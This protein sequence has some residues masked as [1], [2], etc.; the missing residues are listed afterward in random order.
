MFSYSSRNCP[1]DHAQQ[2]TV[3]EITIVQF[4]TKKH[5]R[6]CMPYLLRSHKLD[7][8]VRTDPTQHVPR[9]DRLCGC[10]VGNT[11]PTTATAAQSTALT[12]SSTPQSW[13]AVGIATVM[14]PCWRSWRIAMAFSVIIWVASARCNR[15]KLGNH[16]DYVRCHLAMS[17]AFDSSLE[18]R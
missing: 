8:G 5:S 9:P 18:I 17:I 14:M 12:T 10:R 4:L 3:V 11:S 2:Q 6:V 16:V 15:C 7:L 13:A 1:T